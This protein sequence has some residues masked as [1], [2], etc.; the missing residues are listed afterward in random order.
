MGYYIDLTKIS[1]DAY[2]E[3]LLTR[4][5][6]PSQMILRN[7]INTYFER[8]K[9]SGIQNMQD[10]LIKLKTKKNAQAL[11]KTLDIPE[12]Y[13]VVLRREVGGHHPPARKIDEYPTI[14][15][16]IKVALGAEGITLSNQLYPLVL[17]PANR[18]RLGDMVQASENQLLHIAKLMDVTRLRY[19]SPLFAILLVHSSYD[20]VAKI[21]KADPKA[22]YDELAEINADQQ[23]FKGKLG[24]NDTLFLIQ[25][26]QHV[27]IDLVI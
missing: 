24:K 4:Y 22:M 11:A 21:S 18:K 2:R 14:R 20:T 8:L 17:T 7:N 23:F 27:A 19:V 15:D 25:D 10:L 5:L 13:M 12:D 1:M 9:E 16:E 6:I 26:T 3:M